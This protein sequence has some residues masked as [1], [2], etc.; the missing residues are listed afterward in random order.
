MNSN[1]FS[2]MLAASERPVVVYF[3]APW[4]LPCRFVSPAVEKLKQ[5]FHGQV[6]ILKLNAD[7]HPELLQSL[8]I[9]GIPTL[10][11]FEG[12]QEVDRQIGAASYGALESWLKLPG[13]SSGN[14]PQSRSGISTLDRVLRIL[15]GFLIAVIAWQNGPIWPMLVFGGIVAFWG[16]Y[17][18]CPIWQMVSRRVK[19]QL[20]RLRAA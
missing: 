13:S 8:N 2:Q 18:R 11:R 16:V 20:K 19:D 3:W 9:Y 5:N 15:S 1:E 4:C 10:I 6:E 14:K 7:E 17:D 12:G